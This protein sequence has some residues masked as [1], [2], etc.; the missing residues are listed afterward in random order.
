M[1]RPP[2]SCITTPTYKEQ[3]IKPQQSQPKMGDKND[4]GEIWID[5]FGWVKDTDGKTNANVVDSKG[6]IKKSE[7]LI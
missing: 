2:D 5:G 6:D 4:K 1:N 3:D 7:S